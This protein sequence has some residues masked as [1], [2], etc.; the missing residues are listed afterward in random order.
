MKSPL[1]FLA[2]VLFLS[3]CKKDDTSK[4]SPPPD[5]Y[6]NSVSG[7]S[8]TYHQTDL[9]GIKPP[10]DYTVTSTSNDTTINS[11]KYHVYKYSYGGS[12]YLAVEGHD[13]YQY[14][15][16]PITGGINIERVYLKDNAS[17]GD[18]WKQDFS[19]NIPNFPLAV[20]LTVQNKIAEK[21]ISRTINGKSFSNVFHVI[22]TL[23]SLGIP[24]SALSSN[25]D[26][27]YA[28]GYGLIENTT[29][30]QLNYLGFVEN[31]NLKTELTSSDLK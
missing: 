10:S 31:V 26:S 24:S 29:V 7:S 1:I 6:A 23:S 9:S 22:T 3:A 5:V 28:P 18:T 13:Y 2:T 17:T 8:W 30:I 16:I 19:L 25:I 14:D 11:R 12:E 4:N 21:G 27:Y 15:S 20:P